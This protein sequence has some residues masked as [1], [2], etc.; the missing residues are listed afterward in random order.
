MIPSF[1]AECGVLRNALSAAGLDR[2][3]MS[4][5]GYMRTLM[6]SGIGEERNRTANWATRQFVRPR[7]QFPARR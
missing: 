4:S 7:P 6:I 5:P 2:G 1:G 3:S